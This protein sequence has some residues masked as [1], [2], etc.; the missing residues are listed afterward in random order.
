[1]KRLQDTTFI[2]ET[3]RAAVLLIEQQHGTGER[4]L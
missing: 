3:I 1:M 4:I 2:L